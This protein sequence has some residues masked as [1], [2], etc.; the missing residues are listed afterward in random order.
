M[1]HTQVLADLKKN[2]AANHATFIYSII[3]KKKT[4][5]RER[6]SCFLKVQIQGRVENTLN[7][8]LNVGAQEIHHLSP[9]LPLESLGTDRDSF[10]HAQK[11][12]SLHR[13]DAYFPNLESR[14]SSTSIP[15]GAWFS[16]W[17]KMCWQDWPHMQENV[18]ALIFHPRRKGLANSPSLAGQNSLWDGKRV[19]LSDLL[20][21]TGEMPRL[22]LPGKVYQEAPSTPPSAAVLPQKGMQVIT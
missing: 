3:G 9:S 4:R 15:S 12:P 6:E 16:M 14:W 2:V 18:R 20:S 17:A 11:C 7:N 21:W 10:L 5:E 1:I 22:V 13:L 8:L 19:G